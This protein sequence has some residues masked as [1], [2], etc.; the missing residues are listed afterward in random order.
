MD[1]LIAV[2]LMAAAIGAGV[3]GLMGSSARRRPLGSLPGEQRAPR[4]GRDGGARPSPLERRSVRITTAGHAG[5]MDHAA[6][7]PGHRTDQVAEGSGHPVGRSAK[8]ARP[9]PT[10]AVAGP[11]PLG[12]TMPGTRPSQGRP[13]PGES[14]QGRPPQGRPGGAGQL[15]DGTPSVRI[16]RS[17]PAGPDPDGVVL[18]RSGPS[19]TSPAGGGTTDRVGDGRRPPSPGP[20]GTRPGGGTGREPV[21]APGEQEDRQR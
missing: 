4:L 1:E 18:A 20:S 11:T 14:P 8:G 7:G 16:V 15:A 17:V 2:L 21:V 10:R 13:S 3:V 12:R 9:G 6:E 19:P 5:A